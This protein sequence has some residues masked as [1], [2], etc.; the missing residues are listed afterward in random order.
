MSIELLAITH[1]RN[2][3][4]VQLSFSSGLNII[5]GENASGKTSLLEAIHLLGTGRS[6]RTSRLNHV[7]QSNQTILTIFAQLSQP[8]D[9]KQKLGFQYAQSTRKLKLDGNPI[10]SGADLAYLLPIQL[11]NQQSFD[12]IDQGP[13]QRRKFLD[14]GVF[15]VEHGFYPVWQRYMRAM[16]QRNAALRQSAIKLT[17]WE[18]EMALSAEQLHKY[19]NAYI[20]NLQPLFLE[21]VK[22][23]LGLD[24]ICMEYR[25]GWETQRSLAELLASCREK[26]RELGYSR[27]GPQRADIVFKRNGVLAKERLSRGQQKLIVSALVLGQAQLLTAATGQSGTVLIDDIS[28]ELDT[29]HCEKLM[30]VLLSTGAQLIVTAISQAQLPEEITSSAKMFHVKHGQIKEVV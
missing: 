15:H 6:F 19:R 1:C 22:D 9:H 17:H 27:Y 14:W 24:D 16:K 2:L 29:G 18:Q 5:T 26:D 28:A 30:R 20:E 10:K 13:A 11:I 4:S 25:P 8:D 23:M 3:E 12:L 21:S 7:V